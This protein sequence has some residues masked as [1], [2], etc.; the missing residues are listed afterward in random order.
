[1]MKNHLY[2]K[3][4]VSNRNFT[5]YH[6][7]IVINSRFFSLNCQNPGF[8]MFSGNS[9]LYEFRLNFWGRCQKSTASL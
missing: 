9:D 4:I 8:S 2:S 5:I 3:F 1:M 6:V 7:K